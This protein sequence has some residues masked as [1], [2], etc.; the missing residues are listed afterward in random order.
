M[1]SWSFNDCDCKIGLILNAIYKLKG[2]CWMFGVWYRFREKESDIRFP[3][4]LYNHLHL[5]FTVSFSSFFFS[6]FV[7]FDFDGPPAT[8]SGRWWF[9]SVHVHPSE[10]GPTFTCWPFGLFDNFPSL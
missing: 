7:G 9:P 6:F 5:L 1:C 8:A 4:G 10:A 3:W 2:C